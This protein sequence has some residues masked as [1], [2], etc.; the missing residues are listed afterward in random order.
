MID[1]DRIIAEAVEKEILL[2]EFSRDTL[3]MLL[4][5]VLLQYPHFKE[6]VRK[7]N[8]Y[9]L[10]H[11]L[12]GNKNT[13]NTHIL[14][15]IPLPLTTPLMMKI[16]DYLSRVLDRRIS[17]LLIAPA[18]LGVIWFNR[19]NKDNKDS[20]DK[21]LNRSR[22]L[23]PPITDPPISPRF[24]CSEINMEIHNESEDTIAP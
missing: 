18:V 16:G 4:R 22:L 23:D 3:Q 10:Y 15:T 14:S 8:D 21:Q 24:L 6:E 11:H 17:L 13:P 2:P 1:L 20:R 9:Y 12:P 7:L 5:S 19:S